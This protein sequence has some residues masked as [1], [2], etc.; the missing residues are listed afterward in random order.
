MPTL[1]YDTGALVAAERRHPL[2]WRLHDRANKAGIVP[3]VPVVVLAQAWCGG[4]QHN[5]SRLLRGCRIVPDDEIAGRA[6]GRACAA[7]GTSDV[8]DALVVI[9]A[10]QLAAPVV[11]SDPD[12]LAHLAASLGATLALHPL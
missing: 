5:L 4:P 1:L 8:V 7:A 3:V 6:A 9:T 12:D 11:T 2:I 10:T